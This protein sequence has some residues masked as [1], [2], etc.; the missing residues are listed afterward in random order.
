MTITF[1]LI[2]K[3]TKWIEIFEILSERTFIFWCNCIFTEMLHKIGP[4]YFTEKS[5]LWINAELTCVWSLKHKNTQPIY[6]FNRENTQNS[7]PQN[8]PRRGTW[9][10]SFAFCAMKIRIWNN[11]LSKLFPYSKEKYSFQTLYCKKLLANLVI[12]C[13]ISY[14]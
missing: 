10:H 8:G 11:Y 5:I 2:D 7:E 3:G 14:N 4:L 12:I 1:L 6:I 9:F 13:L